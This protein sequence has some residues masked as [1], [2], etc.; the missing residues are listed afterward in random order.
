MKLL[1]PG[2]IVTG[3]AQRIGLELAKKALAMGFDAVIHCRTDSRGAEQWLSNNP[4]CRRR[5]VCIRQDLA[6]APARL[7]DEA[8]RSSDR[9]VGLVNN[10]SDFSKGNLDDPGHFFSVLAINTLAPLALAQRFAA[11]V[12]NG[13][14]I[15]ITDARTRQFNATYQN[16][17]LSKLFLAEITRQLALL[18]A[19]RIRVNAIAPGAVLPA[20]TPEGRKSFA[21]L[22]PAI[23]LKRT[24]TVDGVLHAFEYL[25]HGDYVTGQVLYVDGGWHLRDD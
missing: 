6:V 17:R 3:G 18:Y 10:A 2:V 13:W 1:N 12:R 7:I 21:A 15:N 19:P 8:A 23:P 5:V 9:L 16:Y 4:S 20:E 24:G 11:C 25:V 22:A 14:I